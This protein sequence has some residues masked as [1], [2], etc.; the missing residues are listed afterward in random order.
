MVNI[1]TLTVSLIMIVT[2]SIDCYGK[3]NNQIIA[4]SIMLEKLDISANSHIIDILNDV[5]SE[6]DSSDS[7]HIYSIY[8]KDFQSGIKVHIVQ[9][10]ESTV[11]SVK[12]L[13]G[14]AL[15]G[16]DTVVVKGKQ[17]PDFSF[18]KKPHPIRFYI[19]KYL[20]NDSEWN[21]IIHDGIFASDGES[22][23][24]IWHIPPLQLK[25]Y[26]VTKYGITAPIRTN[27]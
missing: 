17:I 24:W 12:D 16:K 26:N 4:D 21:Y 9:E 15:I 6:Y 23:G 22:M 20:R 18:S 27:K 13:I 11:T 10:Q 14:Y 8:I 2:L 25:N 3:N 5:T 7:G 1:R 19:N